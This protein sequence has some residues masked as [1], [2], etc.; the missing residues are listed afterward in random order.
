[1]KQDGN[2]LIQRE[3]FS[4]SSVVLTRD[5][6]IRWWAQHTSL[7]WVCAWAGCLMSCLPACLPLSFSFFLDSLIFFYS[8]HDLYLSVFLFPAR[9]VL[10]I[11]FSRSPRFLSAILGWTPTRPQMELN[12]SQSSIEPMPGHPARKSY[13][14]MRL[15]RTTI[16]SG[17]Y[18]TPKLY[19]PKDVWNQVS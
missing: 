19:A 6:P 5:R 4:H 12:P 3:H 17:G 8:C 10:L 9:L 18:L 7:E 2:S 13:W 14:V 15:V 1:M 11:F 16:V